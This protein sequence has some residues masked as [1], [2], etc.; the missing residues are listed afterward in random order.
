MIST[1]S[2]Q[3]YTD[4]ISHTF[5]FRV[6][7]K[8]TCIPPPLYTHTQIEHFRPF[9]CLIRNITRIQQHAIVLAML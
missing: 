9:F 8:L 1:D 3:L 2:I 5:I 4:T 7:G 6:S